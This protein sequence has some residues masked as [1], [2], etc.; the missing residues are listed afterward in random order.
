MNV[1]HLSVEEL[2]VKESTKINGGGLNYT[3][4]E[5]DMIFQVVITDELTNWFAYA[6]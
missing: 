5:L 6:P 1:E 3:K 4:K 2:S